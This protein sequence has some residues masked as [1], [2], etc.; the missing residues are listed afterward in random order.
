MIFKQNKKISYRPLNVQFRMRQFSVYVAEFSSIILPNV[1]CHYDER[2]V[3]APDYFEY[4]E[5]S[6]HDCHYRIGCD[7]WEEL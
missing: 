7:N 4:L 5:S 3:W 6:T 1:R 2:Y